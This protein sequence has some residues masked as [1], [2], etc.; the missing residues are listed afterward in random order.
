MLHLLHSS[1]SMSMGL[2]VETLLGPQVL[3]HFSVDAAV[4]L[5]SEQVL[6]ARAI[7]GTNELAPDEGTAWLARCMHGQT[8]SGVA[9]HQWLWMC[10]DALLEAGAE[11]VR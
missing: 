1:S 5:S 2:G 6:Q 11:A 9:P 7:H 4:G 3:A 10:R 8:L